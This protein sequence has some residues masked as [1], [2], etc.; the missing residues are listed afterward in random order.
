MFNKLLNF[1]GEAATLTKIEAKKR[2]RSKLFSTDEITECDYCGGEFSS[3]KI[4]K[5][6]HIALCSSCAKLKKLA[7]TCDGVHV[8]TSSK[9]YAEHNRNFKKNMA[10]MARR[11]RS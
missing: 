10:R 8:F 3:V 1:A 5:E 4:C 9:A 6:C 2:Y 7:I 11:N